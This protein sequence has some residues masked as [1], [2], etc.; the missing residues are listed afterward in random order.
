MKKWPQSG[1][2]DSTTNTNINT[3]K[4]G[5][6]LRANMTLQLQ[7]LTVGQESPLSGTIGDTSVKRDVISVGQ[8]CNMMETEDVSVNQL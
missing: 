8:C 3:N 1:N 4:M 6:P 7:D 5:A 2:Y